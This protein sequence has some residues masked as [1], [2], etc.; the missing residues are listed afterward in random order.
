MA[1]HEEFK[2]PGSETQEGNGSKQY[3]ETGTLKERLGER[4]QEVKQKLRQGFEQTREQSRRAMETVGQRVE[5]KPLMTLLVAL[6]IGFLFG[7]ML[8]GLRSGG[9]S[10]VNKQ[11]EG[12]QGGGV[13]PTM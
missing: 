5:E 1:E 3:D 13:P 6:G 2:T 10:Q 12:I 4:S 9:P 8:S 11:L 7:M